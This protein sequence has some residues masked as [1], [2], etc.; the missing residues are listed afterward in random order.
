MA[1][2]RSL[3]PP[4]PGD[5]ARLQNELKDRSAHS[6]IPNETLNCWDS[7]NDD[8]FAVIR[9]GV[10]K[11]SR[12][13]VWVGFILNLFKWELLERGKASTAR[14][15]PHVI[16]VGKKRPHMSKTVI[17]KK[18]AST[19]RFVMALF[20]G[21]A[22]IVPTVIMAKIEGINT[23]LITTS[24]AVFLFALILA[25]GATDSTGKDVL[26]ATAAYTA[27]LVVFVGTSLA[28]SSLAAEVAE[29]VGLRNS[30]SM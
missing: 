23:S 16:I 29:L 8:D 19:S 17:A 1:R 13:N 12:L 30:T 2:I 3:E 18:N 4:D 10:G 21:I 5:I 24:I 7:T 25:F 28:G 15:D 20:G 9:S 26:G 6:G 27:V 22:L 11:P 14:D